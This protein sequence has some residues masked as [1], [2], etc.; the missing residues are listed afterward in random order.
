MISLA[1]LPAQPNLAIDRQAGMQSPVGT[2]LDGSR[3]CLLWT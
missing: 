2:G 3:A 1:I